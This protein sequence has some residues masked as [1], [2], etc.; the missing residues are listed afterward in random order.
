MNATVTGRLWVDDRERVGVVERILEGA[1]H[2]ATRY[3]E[4]YFCCHVHPS[5]AAGIEQAGPVRVVADGDFPAGYFWY[6]NE[7]E[8]AREK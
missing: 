8:G 6:T 7:T 2:Y 1:R 3:N 5:L 4:L